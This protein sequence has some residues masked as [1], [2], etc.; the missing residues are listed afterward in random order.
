VSSQASFASKSVPA[1][2]S[3]SQ[4]LSANPYSLLL[5]AKKNTFAYQNEPCVD[6]DPACPGGTLSTVRV[7]FEDLERVFQVRA[8]IACLRF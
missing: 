2:F 1:I 7:L 4:D 6:T 5:E 3:A 8:K